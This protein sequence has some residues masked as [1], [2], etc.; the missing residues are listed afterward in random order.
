MLKCSSI[1]LFAGEKH[2]FD[3]DELNLER[4]LFALVGR[5]GSGKSTFLNALLSAV[6]LATG[7][8]EL[9]NSNVTDLK[10][11]ELAKLVSLVGSKPSVFGDYKVFD[12]LLLGRLPY[13]NIFAKTTQEDVDMVNE[14]AQFMKIEDLL[15][16]PYQLLS[17]G[18]KQ[19]ILVARALIQ[20]TPIILLDEPAAFLDMVNRKELLDH[21]S[22]LAKEKNKLI[23]FSTHHITELD[24]RCDGVL[25]IHEE[26]MQLLTDKKD[27]Y[28]T[29]SE[30][31]QLN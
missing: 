30:A 17:D 29:I 21:L 16:K 22:N 13:Q 11:S 27:Y 20:D 10:P 3:L 15:S 1:S 26:K 12:I 4:G 23:L 24:N 28:R 18:E 2:L 8:I 14:I 5:N 9:N 7:E 19:L 6:E 25:L 31:F